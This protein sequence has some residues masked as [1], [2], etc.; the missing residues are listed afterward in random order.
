MFGNQIAHE[1]A[2]G[3]T[4]QCAAPHIFDSFLMQAK[5]FGSG[6][7]H[8]DTDPHIRLCTE[9]EGANGQHLAVWL[10]EN[11]ESGM[12]QGIG[13]DTDLHADWLISHH[14]G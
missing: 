1:F 4:F 13:H 10:A 14:T 12:R 7:N 6:R 8:G 2:C 9:P 3:T 5:S 11:L